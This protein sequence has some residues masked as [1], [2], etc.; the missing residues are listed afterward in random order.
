MPISPISGA[1]PQPFNIRKAIVVNSPSYDRD[2]DIITKSTF[3]RIR[4]FV[5]DDCGDLY[6][7]RVKIYG[8][9]YQLVNCERRFIMSYSLDV[10]LSSSITYSTQN[11]DRAINPLSAELKS[12]L[13]NGEWSQIIVPT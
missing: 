6:A 11:M 4:M 7:R 9:D 8:E 1:F 12:G 2:Q 3:N 13:N 10:R 5:V